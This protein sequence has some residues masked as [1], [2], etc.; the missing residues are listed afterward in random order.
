[1]AD[2]VVNKVRG[3]DTARLAAASGRRAVPRLPSPRPFDRELPSLLQDDEFCVGLTSAL[4]E[5]IAPVFATLD[6]WDS[7]L[8]PH[9]APDDFV[10]WVASWVGV[11]IDE[12]WPL[13]RRRQL[14]EDVVA[15]YRIR[16]TVAGLA[17]HLHLYTAATPEILE[18]GGCRWSQE[19][20]S[21]LPGTA[22]AVMAVR[23]RVPDPA[24]INRSTVDR[25]VAASRPA[26]LAYTVEIIADEGETVPVPE[27]E[28]NLGP[29]SGVI[30]IG[31]VGLPGSV[32]IDMAPPGPEVPAI[33]E[34]P[35]P[36]APG[37][38]DSAE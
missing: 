19:A 33:E 10:D 32:R 5:V 3:G 13:D 29:P 31:A 9:L 38:K 26:H 34:G 18:N 25:I 36:T 23:L 1:M 24:L 6:C 17:A 35:G 14:V 30:S 4:D 20:D 12:T 22:D 16:G 11:D 21:P 28:I 37:G 27:A 2:V 7:Y 15:L 8:D